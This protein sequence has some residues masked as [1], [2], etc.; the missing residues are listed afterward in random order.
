VVGVVSV[1]RLLERGLRY[2]YGVGALVDPAVFVP[3]TLTGMELI[4]QFRTKAARMVMVVDEYGVVQGLIT[5]LDVLEAI[6]GELKPDQHDQAWAIH[7]AD[8]SWLLEGQMPVAELKARL[9]IEQELPQEDRGRYSTLAGLLMTVSGR[10]PEHG[11][12]VSCA[13]WQFEITA[14]EGRRIDKVRALALKPPPGEPLA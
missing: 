13:H 11:E 8:G 9:G 5:P 14:L 2:P 4:E 6:T 7:Q 12:K 3:E 10:M 1:A